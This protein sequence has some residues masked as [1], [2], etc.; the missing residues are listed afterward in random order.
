MAT[1]DS[2][3]DE[4]PKEEQIPTSVE[5]KIEF[6]F[7]QLGIIL[8]KISVLFLISPPLFFAIQFVNSTILK[9]KF[10]YKGHGSFNE[11]FLNEIVLQKGPPPELRPITTNLSNAFSASVA[12][13]YFSSIE[14]LTW[15]LGAMREFLAFEYII[16]PDYFTK[17]PDKVNAESLKE[18]LTGIRGD[19]RPHGFIG[20]IFGTI[21]VLFSPLV[22]T[23]LLFVVPLLSLGR[24]IVTLFST[25]NLRTYIK[26][27]ALL[28][29]GL[30][31][32]AS[33]YVLLFI[34]TVFFCF[35]PQIALGAILFILLILT[36]LIAIG[37]PCLVIFFKSLLTSFRLITAITW[38][39]EFVNNCFKKILGKS[40]DKDKAVNAE[41][42]NKEYS[43][44][45]VKHIYPGHAKQFAPMYLFFLFILGI[46]LIF[47]ITKSE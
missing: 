20:T 30:A 2:N 25:I 33:S 45:G 19:T 14:L 39:P 24:G 46:V 5:G 43:L 42:Y 12:K 22:Y 28:G 8:G 9:K 44:H 36:I 3:V 18:K 35:I 16:E 23:L 31:T 26:L 21:L 1:T 29:S 7:K 38:L 11:F 37:T 41:T 17:D 34:P 13:G 15:V 4:N 32:Y 6:F 47:R 10:Q 27:I 40:K